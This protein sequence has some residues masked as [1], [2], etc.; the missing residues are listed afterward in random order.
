M[1]RSLHLVD[2]FTD[3]PCTGNQLAVVTGAKGL[4]A[5]QMQ[6]FAREMNFSETTFVMA[7]RPAGGA[8]PV[9]IFTPAEEVP[10]AGHPTLGSAHVI[11]HVL[12]G[13][14]VERVTLSL[15]AGPIPVVY[16]REGKRELYWMRQNAPT[17]G[18]RLSRREVAPVLGLAPSDLDAAPIEEV[19]TGLPFVIVP[20]RTK[21][22][23]ERIRVNRDLLLKFVAGLDA[24]AILAFAKG[25]NGSGHHL[26]ARVF[27]DYYG[28]PE[29]PATGSAN[30]CLAAWLVQHR[31]LGDDAIDVRVEQG[32]S[33]G[34]P[35]VLHL[36][37]MR[38]SRRIE[39]RVGGGVVD[40]ARGTLLA[41]RLA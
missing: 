21:K 10:F 34:R 1:S 2:V 33:I 36:K 37:A 39:V 7:D 29:D 25:A 8:W 16:E 13:G 12:L 23:L 14:R 24:K 4:T 18:R 31:W 22:A 30:G 9:R 3:R 28:I 19:S 38:T 26:T 40:V 6:A 27:V 5:R 41:A 15:A 20:V 32:M 17:F 11:R 35:S